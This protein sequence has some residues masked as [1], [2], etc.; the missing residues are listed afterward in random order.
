MP[1]DDEVS[2]LKFAGSTLM[3]V[4]E[5]REAALATIKEDPYV[6]A[7]VWDMDKVCID[8]T[9]WVPGRVQF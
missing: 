4:A 2:S 3:I 1:P 6:K 7:G 5:S 9:D 8:E